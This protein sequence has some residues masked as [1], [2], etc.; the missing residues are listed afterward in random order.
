MFPQEL[1]DRA[2][3]YGITLNDIRKLNKVSQLERLIDKKWSEKSKAH[4]KE[5]KVKSKVTAQQFKSRLNQE[6][7]DAKWSMKHDIDPEDRAD[8]APD[9]AD[10]IIQNLKASFK[11][12]YTTFAKQFNINKESLADSIYG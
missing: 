9:L 7:K 12:D 4:E 10:V 3:K 11:D 8:A 6:I 5:E 1:I 2:K